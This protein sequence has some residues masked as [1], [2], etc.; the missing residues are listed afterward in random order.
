MRTIAVIFAWFLVSMP[1]F[2]TGIEAL[3]DDDAADGLKQ[4]LTQGVNVAVDRLGV[5]NGFL[6]NPKVKIYLPGTLQKLEGVMRT[7]G[8]SKHV[9]GLIVTMNRVAEVA[10]AE[11][12]TL[13]VDTVEKLP[14]ENAKKILAEGDDAATQYFR[15]TASEELTQEFLPIVKNATNQVDLAKKYNDFVRKGGKFG[16]IAEKY[17][18]IEGYVTQKTLDGLYLMMAE[19][20]RLIRNEPM[21]QDNKVLQRVFG[22][23]K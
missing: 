18:N 13:M 23:L 15:D 1:A 6:D 12:R 20:E 3:S 7:L 16:L 17:A 5:A 22:S 4:A 10:A 2:A 21:G 9:D 11:A 14:V 19:E 8:A